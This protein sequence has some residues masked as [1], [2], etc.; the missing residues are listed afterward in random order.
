MSVTEAW[1]ADA[2]WD[3]TV[4]ITSANLKAAEACVSSFKEVH[5]PCAATYAMVSELYGTKISQKLV[6]YLSSNLD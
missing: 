2:L 6:C 3:A 4:S 1:F 5:A